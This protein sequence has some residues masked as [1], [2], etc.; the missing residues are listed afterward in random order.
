MS[1]DCLF[2][3]FLFC[4]FPNLVLFFLFFYVQPHF[5]FV[6]PKWWLVS[7]THVLSKGKKHLQPWRMIIIWIKIITKAITTMTLLSPR[8]ATYRTSS[9]TRADTAVEPSFH[10]G[11][12]QKIIKEKLHKNLESFQII[13]GKKTILMS[14]IWQKIINWDGKTFDQHGIFSLVHCLLML[15]TFPKKGRKME[16]PN[17]SQD[18]ES[19]FIIHKFTCKAL[20]LSTLGLLSETPV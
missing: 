13:S 6:P 5:C 10:T 12:L 16:K 1:C 3:Y 2:S 14:G 18:K 15:M 4:F 9:T 19:M 20:K 7:R 8:F 17:L 11:D